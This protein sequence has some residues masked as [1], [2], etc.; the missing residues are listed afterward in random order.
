MNLM[1]INVIGFEFQLPICTMMCGWISFATNAHTHARPIYILK[2]VMPCTP[3]KKQGGLDLAVKFI[4]F[5]F[6]INENV[7][8]GV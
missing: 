6:K 3:R 4:K 5:Q 1:L 2:W 7:I 8:I